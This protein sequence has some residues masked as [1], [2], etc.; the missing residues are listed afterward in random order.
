MTTAAPAFSLTANK[1]TA[2]GGAKGNFKFTLG[3][4]PDRVD[5]QDM[6]VDQTRHPKGFV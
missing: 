4:C 5:S 2:L 3:G 6:D 1:I